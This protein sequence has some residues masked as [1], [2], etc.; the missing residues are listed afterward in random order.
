MAD[1]M[2]RRGI[3]RGAF[4]LR[5]LA[6][7]RFILA[8][9]G[10]ACRWRLMLRMM[11]LRGRWRKRGGCWRHGGV[12]GG[13]EGCARWGRGVCGGEG[14]GVSDGSSS[15]VV[16]GMDEGARLGEVWIDCGGSWTVRPCH[17]PMLWGDVVLCRGCFFRGFS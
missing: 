4:I 3:L 15:W 9:V 7:W 6:W 13:G 16:G 1:A 5:R 14:E 2:R 11:L 17:A 8:F 10:H 12:G